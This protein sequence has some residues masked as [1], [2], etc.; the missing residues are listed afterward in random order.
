MKV[1]ALKLG[2]FHHRSRIKG[3]TGKNGHRALLY[4]LCLGQYKPRRHTFPKHP[5]PWGK[6]PAAGK[7]Q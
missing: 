1:L 2:H 7:V 4:E 3:K 5:S 6:V